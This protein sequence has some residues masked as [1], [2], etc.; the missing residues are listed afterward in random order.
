MARTK[1]TGPA[2]ADEAGGGAGGS[3]AAGSADAKKR[4]RRK[5]A[6]K[7]R[8]ETNVSPPLLAT[9]AMAGAASTEHESPDP[10]ASPPRQHD[11]TSARLLELLHAKGLTSPKRT[12]PGGRWD[13]GP[14]QNSS[15]SPLLRPVHRSPTCH[16][17]W[18]IENCQPPSRLVG[19]PLVRVAL[20]VR[21]AGSIDRCREFLNH[22]KSTL[23]PHPLSSLQDRSWRG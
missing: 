5:G 14:G 6:A 17:F 22:S 20:R 15:T 19:R 11:E 13:S 1:Q 16:I 10:P 7:E 12:S 9:S 2:K 21:F 3:V 18:D 8:N 4:R 23:Y